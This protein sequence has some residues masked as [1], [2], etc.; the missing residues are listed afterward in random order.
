PVQFGSLRTAPGDLHYADVSGPDG[1]PDGIV[2]GADRVVIG[3]PFPLWL[4]GMNVSM[5]YKGMDLSI[6][7]QGTGEVDR[8]MTGNGQLP[9][10]DERSNA[11]SYWIDRWTPEN[12]STTLPRLGG[13]NNSQVSSFYVEDASYLRIKN[14]E[15]GYSLPVSLMR[16]AGI[17]KMRLF[18][19]GHNLVTFTKMKNFDPE[20]SAT[21]VGARN[22]P[23]YKVV[24]GG[25]NFTF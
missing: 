6:L 25:L 8:L 11:L 3:N 7:A 2:D 22:A 9:F 18:V 15:L 17:G 1:F 4:Y 5:S 10:N 14:I 19:S 24:T 13:A 12:P 16:K 20:R 23:L 21:N